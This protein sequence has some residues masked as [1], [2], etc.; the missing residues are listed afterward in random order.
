VK[1]RLFSVWASE[2]EY[3]STATRKNER[4]ITREDKKK[5]NEKCTCDEA[6]P[7]RVFTLAMHNH[8]VT[9]IRLNKSS[10]I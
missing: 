7:N 2:R 10:H 5:S 3:N 4:E 8:F 1:L 6:R 9:L